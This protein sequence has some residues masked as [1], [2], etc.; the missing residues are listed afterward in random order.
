MRKG[1]GVES[2]VGR[3]D[4]VFFN[5]AETCSKT[6]NLP[7]LKT[8]AMENEVV[9][10]LLKKHNELVEWQET[11]EESG[12]KGKNEEAA[13]EDDA[14]DGEEE[15]AGS[16]GEKEQEE[17]DEEGG[18]DDGDEEEETKDEDETKDGDEE[19]DEA[20]E[21]EA[22]FDF[23]EDSEE[24][25]EAR[26]DRKRKRQEVAEWFADENTGKHVTTTKAQKTAH[27]KRKREMANLRKALEQ[28]EEEDAAFAA[29]MRKKD[30]KE[31][32]EDA[33]MEAEK[34][35]EV[36]DEPDVDEPEWMKPWHEVSRGNPDFDGL[37]KWKMEGGTHRNGTQQK[38]SKDSVELGQFLKLNENML[39][40]GVQHFV[41]KV[42][43]VE[44]AKMVPAG[45]NKKKKGVV[46][47]EVKVEYILEL[48][49]GV[50]DEPA[51]LLMLTSVALNSQGI[52]LVQLYFGDALE[53]MDLITHH[54]AEDKVCVA[55]VITDVP[56]GQE[57]KTGYN[58]KVD[59]EQ[60]AIKLDELC[61]NNDD[62]QEAQRYADLGKVD[63]DTIVCA[64]G[65]SEALRA[66]EAGWKAL[67]HP[68]GFLA[69][70]VLF[71]FCCLG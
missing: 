18:D 58:T 9:Q 6:S 70:T 52:P 14:E 39:K 43:S 44:V 62:M 21:E 16:E 60:F 38:V 46:L 35:D 19:A 28:H 66:L 22:G 65:D 3:H 69:S 24:V 41:H 12:T 64:L 2:G 15:K 48:T 71:L 20:E 56:W 1:D 26:A 25:L 5:A 10:D 61:K 47:K 57:S 4:G 32:K 42:V 31:R 40:P 33:E 55:A 51:S 50:E 53:A 13:P 8:V 36:V 45:K 37:R 68:V 63:G 7:R 34:D 11:A 54:N 29:W 17:G 59:W 49:G 23:T 30:A 27:A 67:K